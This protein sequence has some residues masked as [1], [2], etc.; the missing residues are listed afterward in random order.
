[1]T[2]ANQANSTHNA[3]QAEQDA[4]QDIRQDAIG[5][6]TRNREEALTDTPPEFT[7]N[8]REEDEQAIDPTDAGYDEAVGQLDENG[9][10]EADADAVIEMQRESTP[11]G[12]PTLTP[13]PTAREDEDPSALDESNIA[14]ES[15]TQNQ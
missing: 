3:Q 10:S 12:N 1:M 7:V 9:I 14:G 2:N 15:P 6:D 4:K 5:R 11:D 13:S 8:N